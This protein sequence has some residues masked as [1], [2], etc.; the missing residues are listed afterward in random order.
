MVGGGSSF[1]NL[2]AMYTARDPAGKAAV[3]APVLQTMQS[4]KQFI[5]GFD[6]LKMRPDRGFVVSGMPAGA[7]YRGTSERGEQYAMYHHHSKLK[8][9][10]YTVLPGTYQ[11]RLILELPAGTYQTDWVNPADGAVVGTETFTHQ[12]GQRSVTTP[13][14]AV[15]MA[16]RIKRRHGSELHTAALERLQIARSARAR[17]REPDRNRRSTAR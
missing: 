15:D 13:K 8:P 4:L 17:Y 1:N 16:L 12:G 2:N 6:F 3:N 9:Y 10:V 5:E 14:H 11:E 7:Y